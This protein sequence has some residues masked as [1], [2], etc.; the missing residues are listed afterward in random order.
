[1]RKEEIW[2]VARAFL[3]ALIASGFIIC[4]AWFGVR[5]LIHD[6]DLGAQERILYTGRVTA[7]ESGES[8]T[9]VWLNSN[10][11]VVKVYGSPLQLLVGGE[12]QIVL[13]GN[14]KLIN[15]L[16]LNE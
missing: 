6:R 3:V 14:G 2:E 12:Y 9:L 10:Q 1:M 7:I 16:I 13:D 8:V 4:V 15:A 11:Q 5:E